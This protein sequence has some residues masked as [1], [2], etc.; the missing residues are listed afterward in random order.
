M[1]GQQTKKITT[2]NKNNNELISNDILLYLQIHALPS[3]HL[4]GQFWQQVGADTEP[5]SNSMWRKSIR[6]FSLEPGIPQKRGI[7]G[8]QESKGMEDIKRMWLTESVKQANHMLTVSEAASTEPVC[9]APGPVCKLCC[10]PGVLMGLLT[11]E[12]YVS[13]T[14]LPALGTLFLV[15]FLVYPGYENFCPVLQYLVLS[16]FLESCSFLKRKWRIS[17]LG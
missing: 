9:S 3:H 12:A 14:L 2:T 11:G 1:N 6:F 7:E 13:L 8:F 10:Q 17:R 15:C 4:R 5:Q 16:S